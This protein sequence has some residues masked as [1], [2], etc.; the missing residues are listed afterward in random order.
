VL[1]QTRSLTREDLYNRIPAAPKE[2][3]LP[4][5]AMYLQEALQHRGPALIDAVT[6]PNALSLP[7]TSLPNSR[8]KHSAYLESL[9]QQRQSRQRGKLHSKEGQ[10]GDSG[11]PRT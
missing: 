2:I 5:A 9:D 7:P 8:S 4:T 10:Q 1:T 3:E 11:C 6:D